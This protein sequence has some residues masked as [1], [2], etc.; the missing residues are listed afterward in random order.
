M[1]TSDDGPDQRALR[2]SLHSLFSSRQ[3]MSFQLFFAPL[4]LKHQFQLVAQSQLKLLDDMLRKLPDC[5]WKKY[6]S[7]VATLSHTWRA[8]LAKM[9]RTWMHQHKH[10]P[11]VTE[12]KATYN[13]PPLAVSS[14]WGSV[15]SN[16]AAY[17]HVVVVC[18]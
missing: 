13:L 9:Q 12:M 4:C 3:N 7:S 16:T 10:E 14:R 15:D 17:C 6:Y 2:N 5:P 11:G 1:N 8:H 18:L